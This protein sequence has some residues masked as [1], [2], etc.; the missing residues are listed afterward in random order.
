MASTKPDHLTMRLYAP[1][2]SALHRAG[3]GGLACTL[4]AIE[5]Q[6]KA[7]RLRESKLPAPF[8]DGQPPWTIDEQTVTL[9]FGRPAYAGEYLKKL[10]TFAF[11]IRTQDGL[12]SLP[13]GQDESEPSAA[14][15]ADLQ[16]GLTLTFLQHGRVRALAKE[17]T[18]ASHNPEGDGTTAVVVEYRKCSGFKHQK[19][20]EALVDK[21]GVLVTGTII[22]DGPISPGTVV[23]HVAFTGDTSVED[24]PERMLPLYFALVGCLSLPVNRGVAALLI[25]DVTDLTEFVL[26]RPAMSPTTATDCQIANAAD[27]AFRA[28][29][30]IRHS[31]R[32]SAEVQTRARKAVAGLTIP[33]CFAMTF[34]PT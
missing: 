27:A 28:Q 12:I 24:P 4:K 26:D 14:I 16:A 19:G 32:R 1:G 34:T 17:I 7:G 10:F 22:V 15:L 8:I 5:R 21:D 6:H 11:A 13:G 33:A 31:P 29:V 3:L 2:M 18:T 25:P 9:R 30:R 23:R 20:W